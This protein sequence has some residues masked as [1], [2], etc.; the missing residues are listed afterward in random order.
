MGCLVCFTPS[1][2]LAFIAHVVVVVCSLL[3]T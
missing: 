2:A 1:G 3:G